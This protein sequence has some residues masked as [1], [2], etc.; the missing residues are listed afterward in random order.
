VKLEVY[1]CQ[2]FCEGY[3]VICYHYNATAVAIRMMI[4]IY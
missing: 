3:Y 2:K 1:V 4:S